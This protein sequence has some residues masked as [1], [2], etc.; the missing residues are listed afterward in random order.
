[1]P[2]AEFHRLTFCTRSWPM[3]ATHNG[4]EGRMLNANGSPDKARRNSYKNLTFSEALLS[5]VTQSSSIIRINIK[6]STK[7]M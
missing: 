4:W 6:L 1:M 7:Q 2:P 5:R 3:S